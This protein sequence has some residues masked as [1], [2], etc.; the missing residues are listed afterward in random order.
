[1]LITVDTVVAH[2]GGALGMPVWLLLPHKPDWRWG[3]DGTATFWYQNMKMFM[4]KSDGDWGTVIKEVVSQLTGGSCG[5]AKS[6]VR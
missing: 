6:V 1:V 4:Q 2:I 3:G 5:I